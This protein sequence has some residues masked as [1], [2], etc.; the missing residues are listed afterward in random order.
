MR[1][2]LVQSPSWEDP[3]EKVMAIHSSILAHRIPWTA[4][5]MGSQKSDTTERL[6]LL[7]YLHYFDLNYSKS[8]TQ[9][10]ALHFH[11][12]HIILISIT[13]NLTTKIFVSLTDTV[14][15]M[16]FK[17]YKINQPQEILAFYQCFL[18]IITLHTQVIF[19]SQ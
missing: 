18:V 16:I 1:E 3:L 8:W 9:L 7:Q 4:Y 13:Q 2:T 17:W 12:T 5:S 6:S 19:H 15:I 14:T 11:N 10:R